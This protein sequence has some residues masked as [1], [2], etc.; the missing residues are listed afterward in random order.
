MKIVGNLVFCKS[1]RFTAATRFFDFG[2][3]LNCY[4]LSLRRLLFSPSLQDDIDTA[5]T[6]V[7]LRKILKVGL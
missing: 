3:I 6:K 1:I 7:K 4:C 2:V 5:K